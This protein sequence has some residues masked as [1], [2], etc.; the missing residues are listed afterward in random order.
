M[1]HLIVG[2]SYVTFARIH[3][4]DAIFHGVY[5]DALLRVPLL[6]YVGQ[7]VQTLVKGR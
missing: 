6:K 5:N 2:S 7:D 1:F 4:E 3:G